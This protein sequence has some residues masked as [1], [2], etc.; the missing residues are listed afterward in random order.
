M[1]EILL[2]PDEKRYVL[3]PIQHM[4][5]WRLYKKHEASFWTSETIKFDHD[6]KDWAK[7]N[8]DEQKFI[9]YVL[10]FFAASDGII[11]E[12]IAQRF[13]NEVQ[14]LE[15]RIFYGFQI[16]MENIHS[17]TYSMMIDL[18]VKDSTE[19][20]FIL[21]GINNI[22]SI[23]RKAD[24]CKKWQDPSRPFGERLVAFAGVEGISFSSSFCAIFWL[25]KLGLLPGLCISNE[26]I[27]SDEA[28][29]FDMGC[30]LVSKLKDKPSVETIK[31]IFSELVEIEMD[32]VEECLQK[33]LK[34]MN[35]DMMKQYVKFVTDQCLE[36]LANCK[37][38]NVSNPFDWM[39]MISLKK[40]V[41]IHER[42]N[43]N[44]MKPAVG[45][46]TSSENLTFPNVKIMLEEET[47]F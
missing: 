37:M 43:T 33:G 38:Y 18:F 4:D 20:E 15:A 27:S 19:K 40:H 45:I 34:G 6:L 1:T 28:I 24:F 22:K 36:Q 25:K 35:A 44:Y 39:E 21:N 13:M 30:L 5:I 7:L 23:K 46:K 41:N 17:E 29:H 12:N 31:E 10:A 26:Y 14:V 47:D 42:E 8:A 11:S 3:Y 32:F 9:K 2:T 16:A